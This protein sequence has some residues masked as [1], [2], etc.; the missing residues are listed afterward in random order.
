MEILLQLS[1]LCLEYHF[2]VSFVKQRYNRFMGSSEMVHLVDCWGE[3][4]VLL[5]KVEKFGPILM[6]S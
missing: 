4:I 5:G 1:R 2:Q 3:R 6:E